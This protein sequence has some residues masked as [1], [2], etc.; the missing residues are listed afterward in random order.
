MDNM[1]RLKF[2]N[3]STLTQGMK[4]HSNL[5]KFTQIFISLSVFSFICS[6]SSLFVI[7]H[8]FKLYFSTFPSQLYTHNIDKNNMFLLCNGLLVFVGLTKSFS[9]SSSDDDDKPS[10]IEEKE[11]EICSRSHVLDVEVNEPLLEREVEMRTNEAD[12]HNAAV[13]EKEVQEKVEKIIFIEEEQE[14]MKD[15]EEEVELF[16]ADD[17]DGDKGSE[18][19]YILIEENNIEEEEHEEEEEE[20]ESSVLSTEELNKKF[21]DFIRK[22]KEDLRIDARR[23]LVMV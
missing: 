13:E 16:D 23:H 12:E 11:E 21:E 8:Y 2:Q 5:M 4:T 15:V 17:E 10:N 3:I 6:P 14:E 9:N 19:D 1:C 7:L 20:E 18:I 22:M